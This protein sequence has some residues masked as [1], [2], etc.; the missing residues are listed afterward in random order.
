MSDFNGHIR[1]IVRAF[2]MHRDDI[3]EVRFVVRRVLRD[4]R[5]DGWK[6]GYSD[7]GED[8][9][10]GTEAKLKAAA[11]TRDKL[12]AALRSS[13]VSQVIAIL[14]LQVGAVDKLADAILEALDGAG[15][16]GV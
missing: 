8:N 5:M 1:E 9:Y 14:E 6:D 4:E 3:G 16:T 12:V 13:A 15:E 2:E 11:L 7:G 10:Y